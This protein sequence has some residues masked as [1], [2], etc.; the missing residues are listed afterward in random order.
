MRNFVQ[1]VTT[2]FYTVVAADYNVAIAS[3][4]Y[5]QLWKSRISVTPH[6]ARKAF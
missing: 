1:L 2:V 6:I 3:D 5:L 4:A